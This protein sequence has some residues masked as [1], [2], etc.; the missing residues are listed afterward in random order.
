MPIDVNNF[1]LDFENEYAGDALVSQKQA[2]VHGMA[3]FLVFLESP[4]SQSK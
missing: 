2:R 3:K 4:K 1:R